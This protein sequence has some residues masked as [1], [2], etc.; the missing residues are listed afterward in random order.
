MMG[1]CGSSPNGGTLYGADQFTGTVA[2]PNSVVGSQDGLANA[3]DLQSDKATYLATST[4]L[5]G[6]WSIRGIECLKY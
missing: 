5:H 1:I 2:C 6:G 3:W 4:E